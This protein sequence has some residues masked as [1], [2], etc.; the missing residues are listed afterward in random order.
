MNSDMSKRNPGMDV[1]RCVAVYSVISVHFLLNNG[2]YKESIIN[3]RMYVMVFMRSFFMICVPL[4]MILSGYLMR[5]KKLEKSYYGKGMRTIW[6]Y[7]LAS[8]ACV[9]YQNVFLDKGLTFSDVVKLILNFKAAPYA[10]YIE[11]Y[12]GLFLM[13]PFLNILYNNIPSKEWKKVLIG[14]FI[15]LTVL[16]SMINVYNFDT[17]N[18]WQTPS[19]ATSYQKIIPQWWR[20]TYPLTY[21]FIGCY[22]NEYGWKLKKGLNILLLILNWC[23]SG[24]Y[25]IW[26]SHG[27]TFLG[28]IWCDWTAL[29]NVIQAVLVFTFFMNLNYDRVPRIVMKIFT[30]L[31][32]LALGAYLVS[33]IFDTEFYAILKKRVPIMYERLEYYFVIV[34]I[35]FC[36]SMALSYILDCIYNIGLRI[37]K[38][39]A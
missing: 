33:W 30:T 36:C 29:F 16:P 35:V 12:L 8:F 4:F 23:A 28:G 39:K 11:M 19:L 26:R 3:N 17:E 34:P 38:K 20:G 22:L 32:N 2:F 14:T 15:V 27:T 21:Y 37:L 5:T 9:I 13:I 25:N 7:L 18:W 24:F 10:W 31:S 6:I 1:I